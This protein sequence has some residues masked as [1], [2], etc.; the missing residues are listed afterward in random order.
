LTIGTLIETEHT[1]DKAAAA[2]ICKDHLHEKKDY[3]KDSLFKEERAKALKILKKKGLIKAMNEEQKKALKHPNKLGAGAKKR[4]HL[5]GKNKVAVVMKEFARGTLHDSS[6]KIVKDKRQAVAIAMSEAGL[7]KSNLYTIKSPTEILKNKHPIMVLIKAKY[8]K[9]EGTPG[10]YKYYYAKTKTEGKEKQAEPEKKQDNNVEQIKDFKI[11]SSQPG[12]KIETLKTHSDLGANFITAKVTSKDGNSLYATY[13]YTTGMRIGKPQD[14]EQEAIDEFTKVMG[15]FKKV[16][17]KNAESLMKKRIQGSKAINKGELSV[18]EIAEKYKEKK[19]KQ[20]KSE[21]RSDYKEI[22]NKLHKNISNIIKNPKYHNYKFVIRSS[23][24]IKEDIKRGWSGWSWAWNK[25]KDKVYN[26]IYEHQSNA[27]ITAV[28]IKE[29]VEENDLWDKYFP[30]TD[31]EDLDE[32]QIEELIDK[33]DKKDRKQY[34][35]DTFNPDILFDEKTG[36][37]GLKHHDG[38]SCYE[39]TDKEEDE[40]KNIKDYKNSSDVIDQSKKAYKDSILRDSGTGDFTIGDVKIV[41]KI[42]D[43]KHE[44]YLLA[45]KNTDKEE[46]VEDYFNS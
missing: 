39:I 37:W 24:N 36:Y 25:D 22:K 44:Y 33:L 42:K 11:G 38:L 32:S 6:G 13:E 29:W 31:E 1:S 45:T 19:K 21:K 41:G 2:E 20:I 12:D 34:V 27:T 23:D 35:I 8:I 16:Q 4:K 46:D 40:E 5:K 17:G 3:Y 7:S 26:T 43:K 28:S 10:K 30:D 15:E 14:T 18:S 9:R